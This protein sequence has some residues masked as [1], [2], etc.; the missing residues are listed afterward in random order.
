MSAWLLV[1]A[2]I[3]GFYFGVLVVAVTFQEAEPN[4][5]EGEELHGNPVSRFDSWLRR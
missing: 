3:V 5:D 1:P 4:L 2:F